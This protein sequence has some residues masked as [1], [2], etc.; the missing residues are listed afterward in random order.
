MDEERTRRA[1]DIRDRGRR[2]TGG[3]PD[4]VAL[5]AFVLAVVAMAVAAAT[6]QAVSGGV[7]GSGGSGVVPGGSTQTGPRYARIWYGFTTR[8]HRWAHSTSRCESGGNPK[9]IGG[10]GAY[11]GAFQF[12]RPAWHN[13]PKSPGGDPI[14]YTWRTQAVVAVL[15]KHQLGSKPWPVCG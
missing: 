10:G 12:T 13:A 9:A 15:L 4:R 7:G 1:A 14:T 2:P 6:A 8:E 5:W 3:R 11:R